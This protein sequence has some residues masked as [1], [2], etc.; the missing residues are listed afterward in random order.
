MDLL[1]LN[2]ADKTTLR[3]KKQKFRIK[4]ADFKKDAP[5]KQ[6]DLEENGLI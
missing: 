1:T 4:R 6:A 3:K 2:E 5:K